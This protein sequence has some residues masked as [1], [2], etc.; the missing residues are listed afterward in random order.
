MSSRAS[1]SAIGVVIVGASLA[2]RT[3]FANGAP[4]P[5]DP[6]AW[7]AT[8]AELRPLDRIAVVAG[9]GADPE[10]GWARDAVARVLAGAGHD[11]ATLAGRGVSTDREKLVSA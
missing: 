1:I 4:A 11:V 2:S 9:D 3:G 5:D 7:L 10:A 6:V 8:R